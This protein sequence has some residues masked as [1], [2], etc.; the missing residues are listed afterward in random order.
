MPAGG[1]TTPMTHALG[2]GRQMAVIVAGGRG[3]IGTK[4]GDYVIAYSLP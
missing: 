4:V 3:S 2:D 1:Q